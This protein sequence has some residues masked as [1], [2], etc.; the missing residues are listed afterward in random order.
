MFGLRLF[1]T[2]EYNTSGRGTYHIA[3]EAPVS[4]ASG[5]SWGAIEIRE[6]EVMTEL[7]HGSRDT[8]GNELTARSTA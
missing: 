7:V 3:H 1:H 6:L 8:R 5:L 4:N 2:S